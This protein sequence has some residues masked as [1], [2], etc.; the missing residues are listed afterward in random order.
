MDKFAVGAPTRV[1]VTVHVPL[2][3]AVGDLEKSPPPSPPAHS[4]TTSAGRAPRKEPGSYWLRLSAMIGSARWQWRRRCG[5]SGSGLCRCRFLPSAAYSQPARLDTA[6]A[7]TPASEALDPLRRGLTRPHVN[8]TFGVRYSMMVV[9]LGTIFFYVIW[10]LFLLVLLVVLIVVR[11]RQKRPKRPKRP[12]PPIPPGL[13]EFYEEPPVRP[14]PAPKP[15]AA[16]TRPPV[17]YIRRWG[18]Y[19]KHWEAAEKAEWE[20]EFNQ[21]PRK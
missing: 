15:Q 14:R 13:R 4:K 5:L 1:A 21:I 6:P 3:K 17:H 20:K 19:R 11:G 2:A 18:L 8:S 9:I 16:K 10:Y 12:D 7:G